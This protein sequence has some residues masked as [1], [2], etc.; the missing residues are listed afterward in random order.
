[1]DNL[2]AQYT[3]A[4]GTAWSLLGSH[5][6][7]QATLYLFQKRLLCWQYICSA[8]QCGRFW[9]GQRALDVARFMYWP[10]SLLAR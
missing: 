6:N 4:V 3:A 8:G 5:R 2:L 7:G 9:N 10:P 1:M